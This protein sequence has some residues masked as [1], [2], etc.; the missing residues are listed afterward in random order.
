M[1]KCWMISYIQ[2][3]NPRGPLPY[4]VKSKLSKTSFKVRYVPSRNITTCKKTEEKEKASSLVKLKLIIF[5]KEILSLSNQG[6][7]PI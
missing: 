3:K 6:F 4:P 5:T 7:V 1:I 2:M